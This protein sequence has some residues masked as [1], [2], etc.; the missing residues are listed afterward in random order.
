MNGVT[1][2]MGTDDE[3]IDEE[4]PKPRKRRKDRVP[5]IKIRRVLE[6]PVLLGKLLGFYFIL[7]YGVGGFLFWAEYSNNDLTRAQIGIGFMAIG[8]ILAFFFFLL[9]FFTSHLRFWAVR[10]LRLI[11]GVVII[12]QGF[13]MVTAAAIGADVCTIG[14]ILLVIIICLYCL[15]MLRDPVL[16]RL[17]ELKRPSPGRD[18]GHMRTE[19]K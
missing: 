10:G 5:V 7:Y 16:N 8:A 18:P 2:P 12:L 9:S 19:R 6:R 17:S 14:E 1:V 11:C 3:S 13:R 4:E 15:R